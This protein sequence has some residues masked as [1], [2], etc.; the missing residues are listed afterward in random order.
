MLENIKGICP[1]APIGY[2]LDAAELFGIRT[3]LQRAHWLAQMAHESR[4]FTVT[5]ESLN[6]SV[7]ALLSLFGRHR[8]SEAD[9]HKYGRT[10]TQK[11][12]QKAL[13]NILYGGE[14]GRKNLGNTQAGDGWKF[15]GR[16]F[17][18]LTGRANYEACG[19]AT[20][21]LLMT[22]P[23]LLEEPEGA[24]LSA[25]WFWKANGLNALADKDDIEAIT[26]KVNG[27][28]LGLAE[29]KAWLFKFKAAL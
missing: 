3:P 22:G 1:A 12:D 16:G 23:E 7:E 14:F 24:S 21:L 2:L 5:R 9:A 8:I 17:K 20:G 11:A 6:Y 15:I 4:G 13:A 26:R 19:R 18:Q 27:G 29:R 10:A 25:G 28:T